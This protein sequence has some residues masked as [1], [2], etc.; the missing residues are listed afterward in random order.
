MIHS[1]IFNFYIDSLFTRRVVTL[2]GSCH[3]ALC[4]HVFISVLPDMCLCLFSSDKYC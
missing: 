2:I 1:Q 4:V 3:D